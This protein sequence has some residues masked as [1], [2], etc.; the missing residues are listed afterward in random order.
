MKHADKAKGETEWG[1]GQS[2]DAKWCTSDAT[3]ATP[4]EMVL[5]RTVRINP[6]KKVAS[7]DDLT[8]ISESF[9]ESLC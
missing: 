9:I 4:S 3:I 7:K 2:L 8:I 5:C 1:E 6:N